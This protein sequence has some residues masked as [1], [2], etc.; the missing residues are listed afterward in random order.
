MRQTVRAFPLGLCIVYTFGKVKDFPDFFILTCY[1]T[2]CYY[3]LRL[4]EKPCLWVKGAFED[5]QRR[6]Y[7]ANI[8]EKIA[9]KLVREFCPFLIRHIPLVKK[10]VPNYILN[11]YTCVIIEYPTALVY[12]FTAGYSISSQNARGVINR[13]ERKL[14]LRA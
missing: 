9:D 1:V 13:S 5:Y 3:Y 4:N 6:M 14:T 12:R 7:N 11:T 2:R 10:P 8:I